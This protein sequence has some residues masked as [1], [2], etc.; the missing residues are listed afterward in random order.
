MDEPKSREVLADFAESR[1]QFRECRQELFHAL[2]EELRRRWQLWQRV[3]AACLGVTPGYGS[4]RELVGFI[5][6]RG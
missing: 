1:L 3:E 6:F 4:S 2:S 5:V